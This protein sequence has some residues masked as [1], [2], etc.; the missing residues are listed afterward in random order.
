[1]Q[2][3]RAEKG[4]GSTRALSLS[5]C[6]GVRNI[7][8]AFRAFKQAQYHSRNIDIPNHAHR[9]RKLPLNFK[10]DTNYFMLHAVFH[11]FSH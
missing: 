6:E 2:L 8:N 10:L 11:R 4:D 7:Q 5:D 1:M 9:N 3:Q